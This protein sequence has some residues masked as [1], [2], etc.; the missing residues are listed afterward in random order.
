MNPYSPEKCLLKKRPKFQLA[1]NANTVSNFNNGWDKASLLDRYKDL[2]VTVDD[3]KEVNIQTITWYAQELNRAYAVIVHFLSNEHTGWT[4]HNAKNSFIAGLAY[5]FGKHLLMLAH[6]PY[7]S[8][9][10]YRE[11]L[12]SHDKGERCV[13]IVDAWLKDISKTYKEQLIEEKKFISEVQTKAD[14]Q[15]I[16]IGDSV[17]ENESEDLLKY[18]IHT[19]S[20][21]EALASK[22]SIFIGRRG[23]GKTAILYK[24]ANTL[25]SDKRNHVCVIKP[26]DY[27]LEGILRML[28]LTIPKSEKGFLIESFWKFLIYTDIAGNVYESLLTKP[29]YYEMKPEDNELI[30]FVEENESMIKASFSIRLETIV[31]NLQNIESS[32]IAEKD[33]I[34][35]SE[36]LHN[37]TIAK[38]R[39]ILGNILEK[40]NK[41]VVIVDNLDKAWGKREDL[42]PLADLLFGLLNVTNSIASDFEKTDHWRKA[43]NF[44]LI[45]FLRSDIFAQIKK[46]TREP[47]KISYSRISWDDPKLLIKIIEERFFTTT[48]IS[49]PE[50]MWRR[51]FC[52]RIEGLPTKNY[53]MKSILPRPRDLISITQAA[54]AQAVNHGHFKVDKDDIM[55]AK[56]IYSQAALNSLVSEESTIPIE[57]LLY[58]FIGMEEILSEDDIL[59]AMRRCGLPNNKLDEITELLCDTTFLGMEVEK[60]R[61]E[62]LY[63]DENK[64]KYKTMAKKT[65]ESSII[66]KARYRINEPFHAYLEIKSS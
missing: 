28:Q 3:P 60:D 37:K 32:G 33:R 57:D 8:P 65:I 36:L 53:L 13:S 61:F 41:V 31:K 62:F 55:E 26:V 6:E 49:R 51:F 42:S 52:S 39:S 11:L 38:L 29:A 16:W 58:E 5:G 40:K 15:N 17:A 1:L 59:T 27:E 23:T 7:S 34:K 64:G 48:S 44:S 47:D 21:Y 9:I 45:I 30:K 54:I 35:I 12:K 25:Q 63:N 50:A 14:L 24:L 4:F 43:F 22:K 46:Y 2:P 56:K 66:K 19:A 18:F 10:D 20:Y